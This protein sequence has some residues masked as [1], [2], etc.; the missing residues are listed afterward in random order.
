[1][2]L[3]EFRRKQKELRERDFTLRAVRLRGVPPEKTLEV[4]FALCRAAREFASAGRR[5]AGV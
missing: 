1:M 3:A 2:R 5:V 4:L